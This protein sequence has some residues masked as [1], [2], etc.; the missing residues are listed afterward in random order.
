MNKKKTISS[1][2]NYPVHEVRVVELSAILQNLQTLDSEQQ[3][4]TFGNGRSYG[5]APLS[6]TI[7][8]TSTQNK[9]YDFDSDSGLLHC[10]SGLLIEDIINQF[11]PRGWFPQVVPG[12]K[13]VSVGGAIAADIH[14]KNHHKKG[15]FSESVESLTLVLPDGSCVSCSRDSNVD[16]FQ[17]TCGGM[18]LTGIISDVKL[19]LMKVKTRNVIQNVHRTSSLKDTIDFFMKKDESDYSVAWVDT[20]CDIES[21]GRAV[22]QTGAFAGD[23]DL[24]YHPKP[25]ISVSDFVP[26]FLLNDST[27]SVFNT[28]YYN[29]VGRESSNQKITA[30][31]FFFPLDK[32]R[33]WNR[34]YGDSGFRQFQVIFPLESSFDGIKALFKAMKKHELI[35]YLAVLKLYGK[36]NENLLSFPME[37][38]SIAMDFKNKPGTSALFK[39]FDE[40]TTSYS[41]RIY[42]AKD[43]SMSRECFEAGYPN[44]DKFR[45]LR[46]E[47]GMDKTFNSL[48]SKRLGL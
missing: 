21:M 3:K 47:Y 36:Q 4:I 42:L 1:W 28:L 43:A 16:L 25:A 34:L 41:G 22:I 33:D 24:D 30:E 20:S 39:H 31:S 32:I 12:T 37:G 5:D 26:A 27:I 2:G 13:Q 14:G 15:S 9:I 6:D 7:I 46:K 17:A 38:F 29:L 11:L 40:I 48:Q 45:Q 44:A 18:G 8:S 10:E 19:K 35:S 23:G